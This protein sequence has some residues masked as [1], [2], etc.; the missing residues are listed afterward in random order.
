MKELHCSNNH[1][2]SDIH[3]QALSRRDEEDQEREV[4]PPIKA[5]YL[6]N[7]NISNL[8]SHLIG[9]WDEMEVVDIRNNPW[10][11]NCDN[12]WLVDTLLPKMKDRTPELAGEVM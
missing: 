10:S 1:H 7:T 6:H 12:Q 9:R 2:L 3:S 5:L 8:D 11:C 4:W